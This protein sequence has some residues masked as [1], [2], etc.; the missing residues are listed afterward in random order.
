M[1][2]LNDFKSFLVE[3]KLVEESHIAFNFDDYKFGSDKLILR[4][5][6]GEFSDVAR[7]TALSIIVKNS[8]MQKAEA[9]TYSAFDLLCPVKNYQKP[10]FLNGK[11]MLISP[12]KPPYYKE[13]EKNGRH[14]FA[15][16]LKVVHK[17]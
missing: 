17:K 9:L 16:D 5:I 10:M 14:V 13:K 3:N 1:T 7:K 4:C 11:M 2:I 8:D 12:L 15:F 6:G